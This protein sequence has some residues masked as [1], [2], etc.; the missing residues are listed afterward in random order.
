MTTNDIAHLDEGDTVPSG[1]S[2]AATTDSSKAIDTLMSH[3][4]AMDIAYSLAEGMCKTALVPS[5]YRGKPADGTAAILYGAELGLNPIQSLQQIFVV[6]GAPAIYARTM[7]A[8]LKVK[9]YHIWTEESTDESV[10]VCG[11]APSG[12]TESSTWTMDRARKAGYVP[13]VDERT[14]KFKTNDKGNLIGNEKYLKDPQAMLYA[15]AASEVC[16]KIAPDVLLGIAHTREDLELDPPEEATVQRSAPKQRGVAGA[17]AALGIASKQG[18]KA[19]TPQASEPPT[20]EKTPPAAT[21]ADLKRL[22]AALTD[23]GILDQEERRTFLS[24]RVGHELR[25]ARE[26]TRDEV[27][28]IIRFVKEGEPAEAGEPA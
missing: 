17:R 14:G 12:I 3:A 24:A 22:D 6:H 9:G 28:S 19:D 11:Q 20:A 18:E 7:V 27:A 25:A 21:P 15:K 2:F 16:R 10:T 5:I 23:A 8:L 13:E 26:L 4:K 1:A